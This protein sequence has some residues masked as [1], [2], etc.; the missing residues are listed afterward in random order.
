MTDRMREVF[1]RVYR[2][3]YAGG[4]FRAEHPG[5]RVTLAALYRAGWLERR[6]WRGAEGD[7]DAAHEYTVP[8]RLVVEIGVPS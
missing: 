4:W 7:A 6:A 3:T 2:A 5:Q 1:K 8:S